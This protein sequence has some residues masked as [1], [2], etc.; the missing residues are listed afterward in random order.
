MALARDLSHLPAPAKTRDEGCPPDPQPRFAHLL[1]E[2]W[3]EQDGEEGDRPRAR[4]D[5]RFRHSDAGG[6]SRAIA[7]AALGVPASNPM[8]LAGTFTVRLGTLVHD[9]WQRVLEDRYPGAEVEAKVGSGER[10]GHID[11]VVTI[12]KVGTGGA[13]IEKVVAI[14]GK[15]VGGFAYKLAVGERGAP[16]GPKHAHIV[17]AALNASEVNADEAVVV[18]WS[19]DSISVQAAARKRIGELARFCAEWTF[20]RERYE[21]I[22]ENERRRVDSILALLDEG[23]LPGR[24]YPDPELPVRH[25]IVDPKSGRWEQRDDDQIVDTGT[26]WA[27]G[28]CRWQDTCAQTPAGRAPVSTLVDIGAMRRLEAVR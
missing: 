7:Y 10:A 11:A 1:A 17:Q 13:F 2:A 8:D 23:T 4:K 24:R 14:E 16:Q 27:C 12:P 19:K 20:P 26:W 3:A 25:V 28:Y 15:T 21:P 18:Y 5:A 9:A 6:C 22:A